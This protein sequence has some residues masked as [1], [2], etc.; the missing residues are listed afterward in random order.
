MA[1]T[2]FKVFFIIV[3][4]G[5]SKTT[6]SVDLY[7]GRYLK[8]VPTGFGRLFRIKKLGPL[9]IRTDVYNA[10]FIADERETRMKYL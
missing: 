8:R 9:E 1:K 5:Q 7:F 6:H 10:N 4:E 3:L 2:C